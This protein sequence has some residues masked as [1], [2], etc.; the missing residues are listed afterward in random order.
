MGFIAKA[1]TKKRIQ[2]VAGALNEALRGTPWL[3]TGGISTGAIVRSVVLSL[4]LTGARSSS[5][6]G[7]RPVLVGLVAP[8]SASHLWVETN[9]FKGWDFVLG[10]N[11]GRDGIATDWAVQLKIAEATATVGT[12]RYH[13]RDDVLVH[14]EHHDALRDQLL[15]AV[16]LG[17]LNDADA[18]DDISTTALRTAQSFS[19]PAPDPFDVSFSIA[20]KLDS[21]SI[22][23]QCGLLGYRVLSAAPDSVSWGLGLPGNQAT[24]FVILGLASGEL[25]GAAQVRSDGAG[26][27]RIA[28][29]SL[30]KFIKRMHFLIRK[31]DENASYDGPE[32]FKP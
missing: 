1:A 10:G 30:Q 24:D 9:D 27:R 14:G 11:D 31:L 20:T 17:K 8:T 7:R 26:G 32:E 29:W 12:S 23:K 19:T 6:R 15:L 4:D 5:F 22:H 28:A 25:R 13:T 18:E 21:A 2:P 16:A 3:T